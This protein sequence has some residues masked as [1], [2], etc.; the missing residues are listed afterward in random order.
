LCTQSVGLVAAACERA[1][2]ATAML[3]LVRDVA[4]RV[5]PPRALAVPFEFG[6]PLGRPNDVP[7]QLD[8]LRQL[9]A[10]FLESGPPP[11]LRDL[12]L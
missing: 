3:A 11:V 1:G 6:A 9:L 5:R 4:I 8:V 12:I 2:I 7:G 10:L